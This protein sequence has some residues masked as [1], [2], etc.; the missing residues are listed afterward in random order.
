MFAHKSQIAR[1]RMG[2]AIA[3]SVVTFGVAAATASAIGTTFQLFDHPD[4][5]KEPMVPGS[6]SFAMRLD[7]VF[8]QGTPNFAPF[9][10]FSFEE[11]GSN[12]LLTVDDS[13]PGSIEIT[14]SGKIYGGEWDG[15]SFGFGEGAYDLEMVYR[16]N[17][18]ETALGWVVDP[19]SVMNSGSI[20]SQ[21]N[22][23]VAAG[24]SFDLYDAGADVFKFLAD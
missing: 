4:N 16:V 7:G 12:V 19:N 15:G 9:T 21:G 20:T 3:A 17:V 22:A 10:A 23:D 2:S 14:I 13:M 5:Q 6:P 8:R 18:Q 1:R 11:N 24:T